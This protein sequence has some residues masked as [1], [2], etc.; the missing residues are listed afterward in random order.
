[1]G[2]LVAGF[3]LTSSLSAR[4]AQQ[5]PISTS[6]KTSF[7]TILAS[8]YT[9]PYLAVVGPNRMRFASPLPDFSP[10]LAL[11]DSL[12]EIVP[13]E[14]LTPASEPTT[15]A[16]EPAIV[17]PQSLITT[18]PVESEPPHA[19]PADP[20]GPPPVSILPDDLERRV[21]PEDFLP[22]FVPPRLPS[23]PPSQ[24]TYQQR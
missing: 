7:S 19:A 21:T 20:V 9:Q 12:E 5:R 23:A 16:A 6:N 13:T 2:V 18:P 22:F 14:D 4:P 3:V 24:A 15:A 17:V 8:R 10:E 1:L 11:A